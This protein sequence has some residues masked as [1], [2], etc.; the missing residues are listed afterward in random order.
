MRGPS[1]YG[2]FSSKLLTMKFLSENKN[3][4][5]KVNKN[6]EC[7]VMSSWF[8]SS[9]GKLKLQIIN[10]EK[11]ELIRE[12]KDY[13]KIHH[14]IDNDENSR[15][16][17]IRKPLSRP[18]SRHQ[19]IPDLSRIVVRNYKRWPRDWFVR[20]HLGD[21]TLVSPGGHVYHDLATALEQVEQRAPVSD[22]RNTLTPNKRKLFN[23]MNVSKSSSIVRK[24]PITFESKS[25][26]PLVFYNFI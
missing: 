3:K 14:D 7:D 11:I 16:F 15:D 21:T 26:E 12:L 9:S 8:S 17:T 10:D 23:V 24:L 19:R 25:Y 6:S 22:N 1:Q 13:L 2:W 18:Q 4:L 5:K 20:H